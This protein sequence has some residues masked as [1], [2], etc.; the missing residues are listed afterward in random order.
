MA[1]YG[2]D[3]AAVDSYP[4]PESLASG[5][6]NVANALARRWL[7]S[8]GALEEAG[9]TEPYASIN[10]RDYLGARLSTSELRNLNSRAGQVLEDD[11]RV[12]TATASIVFAGGTL[13]GTAVCTGTNGPFTLVVTIDKVSTTA[14]IQGSQP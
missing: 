2:V 13:I 9:E 6:Q 1:D 3:I 4:D 10:L 7:T 8:E 11:P 14:L 5:E 12:A